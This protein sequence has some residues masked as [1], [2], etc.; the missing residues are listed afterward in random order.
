L[1]TTEY[2]ANNNYDQ[3]YL[4]RL[5]NFL[6]SFLPESKHEWLVK[7][8][9]KLCSVLVKKASETPRISKLYS[10]LQTVLLI[11]SKHNYFQLTGKNELDVDSERRNT[12]NML[13]TF[14][15]E[16]IG[17]SEQFQD[18]LLVTTMHLLLQVPIEI[19]YNPVKLVNNSWIDNLHLWKGV[20]LKALTLS[21]LNNRLAMT[22]I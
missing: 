1:R 6:D 14:L 21:Q 19:I 2:V 13:L 5:A 7:W 8:V 15:K 9:P 12:F 18:D 10:L 4:V 11:S 20:I 17:K 3:Q 22:C 16:L